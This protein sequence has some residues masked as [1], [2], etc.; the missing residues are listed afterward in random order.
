MINLGSKVYGKAKVPDVT[1]IFVANL[2]FEGD[3]LN[4][5]YRLIALCQQHLLTRM[6]KVED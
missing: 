5:L 6:K 4:T 1:K 3:W 2:G